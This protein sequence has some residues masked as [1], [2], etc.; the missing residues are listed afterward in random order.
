MVFKLLSVD[1]QCLVGWWS[2]FVFFFFSFTV[3][4][5]YTQNELYTEKKM[6][7]SAR[8]K[9]ECMWERLAGYISYNSP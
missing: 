7:W 3:F 4:P 9:N 1:C 2:F 5:S 8:S 6:L